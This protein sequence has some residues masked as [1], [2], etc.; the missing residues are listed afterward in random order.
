M[1]ADGTIVAAG[2]P[3]TKSDRTGVVRVFQYSYASG[4]WGQLGADID[5]SQLP[6]FGFPGGEGRC[7]PGALHHS[8][9]HLTPCPQLGAGSFGNAVSLSCDGTILAIGSKD[10]GSNDTAGTHIGAAQVFAYDGSIQARTYT[11]AF[12]NAGA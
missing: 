2:G 1:S 6:I 12:R 5:G 7:T 8:E 9:I 3:H 4:S 11:S 10:A